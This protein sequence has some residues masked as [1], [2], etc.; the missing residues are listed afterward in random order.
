MISHEVLA[1]PSRH[2]STHSHRNEQVSGVAATARRS[3]R[4]IN[5]I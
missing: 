1:A 4:S 3:Q 2:P 5:Y